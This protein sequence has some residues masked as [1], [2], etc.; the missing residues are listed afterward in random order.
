MMLY[1]CHLLRHYCL[2]NWNLQLQHRH[3]RRLP[4]LLHRYLDRRY[5][6]DPR[7]QFQ[8]LSLRQHHRNFRRLNRRYLRRLH[9]LRHHR[10]LLKLLY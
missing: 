3:H 2:K 9:S 6:L 10:R 4:F 5:C 1:L 7:Y 8:Q